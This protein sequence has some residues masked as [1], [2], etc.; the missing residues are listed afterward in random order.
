[1][2]VIHFAPFTDLGPLY[3][4]ARGVH[5]EKI[6]CLTLDTER[7]ILYGGEIDNVRRSSYLWE[8]KL[9]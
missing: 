5:A 1:M 9:R 3:D 6:H 8:I 2:P 7:N 4:P